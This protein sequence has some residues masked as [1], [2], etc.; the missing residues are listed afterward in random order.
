MEEN[1]VC[2]GEGAKTLVVACSG[3]S[4]VGQVANNVMLELDKKGI[5]TSYCLAGVGAGLSG[6]VESARAARMVLID[7]CPVGCGRKVFEKY[8]IKPFA[9]F[10]VTELG[11]E[12]NHNFQNVA[13]E[14]EAVIGQ[15]AQE[16]SR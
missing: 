8:N 13:A 3:G 12:K 16:L 1:S 11:I 4:N 9:Y 5:G 10:I 15:V 7:G 2:C 6:F 14:S